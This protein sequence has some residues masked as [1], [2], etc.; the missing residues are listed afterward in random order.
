MT[1]GQWEKH[2]E[3]SAF[4]THRLD[5][6]FSVFSNVYDTYLT[7]DETKSVLEVGAFPG[8]HLGYVAKRFGYAPTAVDYVDNIDVLVRN[9]ESN[10]IDCHV[11]KEDFLAWQPDRQYDVVLSHGFVEH[12]QN[13]EEVI[14]KHI[15]LVAPNGTLFL[16][17]PM[18]SR[19][20]WMFCYL[21]FGK[22]KYKEKLDDHVLEIMNLKRLKEVCLSE[23]RLNV[24]FAG[25][26][27]NYGPAYPGHHWL[28]YKIYVPIV[29]PNIMIVA[30]KTAPLETSD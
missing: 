19:L 16:S 15:D 27:W 2:W 24:L 6:S 20:R 12:F 9:M 7:R 5:L 4:Q 21:Y 26:M 8:Q 30:K 13:Y 29:L 22:K 18:T 3:E 25:Q 23:N 28:K 10:G 17:V 11:I 14:G 1:S